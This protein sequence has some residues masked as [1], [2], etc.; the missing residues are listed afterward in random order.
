VYTAV[1]DNGQ[2]RTLKFDEVQDGTSTYY[3]LANFRVANEE[4]LHFLVE[5]TPEGH[6]DPYH[7]KFQRQFFTK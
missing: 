7:I 5:A 6:S 3:Y 2:L 4:I 1:N